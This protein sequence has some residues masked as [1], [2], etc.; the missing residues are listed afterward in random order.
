MFELHQKMQQQ[1]E[2]ANHNDLVRMDLESKLFKLKQQIINAGD[3]LMQDIN[4]SY[5][6][7]VTHKKIEKFI[8]SVKSNVASVI[9][10]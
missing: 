8:S 9:G 4:S 3:K 1:I 6:D 7:L 2:R 5:N 10:K